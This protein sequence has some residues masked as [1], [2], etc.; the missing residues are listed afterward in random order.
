M[1]V[2]EFL[3]YW[4]YNQIEP[5]G[6]DREDLRAAYTPWLIS[7]YFAK[8]GKAPKY[9]DFLVSNMIA[10]QTKTVEQQR[11]SPEDMKKKLKGLFLST[12]KK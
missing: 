9:E 3:E 2:E 6:D 7:S 10:K 4:T 12:R 11:Q 1:S 5:F 8:K